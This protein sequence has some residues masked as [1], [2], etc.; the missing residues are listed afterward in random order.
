LSTAITVTSLMNTIEAAQADLA[1]YL[2]PHLPIE[3]FVA[4]VKMALHRQPK[5]LACTPKSVFEAVRTA[6]DLG[7]DPSGTLGSAYL[8]P[9]KENCQLIP[10]YRGLIDLAC[11]SGFVRTVN[12]WVIYEKDEFEP[13]YAGRLPKHRPYFPRPDDDP[14]PG[15]VIGAWARAK[16]ANGAEECHVM[17]F[18]KLEAIRLKSPTVRYN[19]TDTPW[20]T[21]TD[22]MYRKCPIRALAKSLPLS[23]IHSSP[24]ALAMRERFAKAIEIEDAELIDPGEGSAPVNAKRGS[25][26]AKARLAAVGNVATQISEEEKAEILRKERGEVAQQEEPGS[27]G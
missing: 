4:Q 19:L 5:L 20:F 26:G 9:Y 17:P 23:P 14:N 13:P 12:A 27:A 24:E 15:R 25:A 3:R 10:G 11:R 2:P 8:V 18:A 7:L 1:K 21:H 22:E 16:M 6:A